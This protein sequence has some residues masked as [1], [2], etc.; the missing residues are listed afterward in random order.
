LKVVL[1]RQANCLDTQLLGDGNSFGELRPGDH[2][3]PMPYL[4]R[5]GVGQVMTLAYRKVAQ[6]AL[7]LDGLPDIEQTPI[8]PDTV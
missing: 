2:H 8:E 5:K 6:P 7:G 1:Q 4:W 3:H